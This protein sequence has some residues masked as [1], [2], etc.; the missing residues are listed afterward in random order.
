[1]KNVSFSPMNAIIKGTAS[2][3]REALESSGL[4]EYSLNRS[5]T[6][7]PAQV[8]PDDQSMK[9]AKVVFEMF[10]EIFMTTRNMPLGKNPAIKFLILGDGGTEGMSDGTYAIFKDFSETTPSAM[11]HEE[12]LN[13][14]MEEFDGQAVVIEEV[15]GSFLDHEWSFDYEDYS[16]GEICAYAFK[17]KKAKELIAKWENDEKFQPLA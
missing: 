2:A 9:T 14:H 17:G 3:I 4:P 8:D 1:M 13:P 16:C 11:W 12:Y 10:N 15:W 5:S 7:N 6:Y